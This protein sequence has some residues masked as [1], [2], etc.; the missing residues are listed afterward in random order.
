MPI[1]KDRILYEDAA[2]LAVNKLSGELVVKGS[3]AVGKL[4]LLDFL[5]KDYPGIRPL[6]RLDFDTSGVVLF[7]RTKA[8]FEKAM[9]VGKKQSHE[10]EL[11]DAGWTKTYRALVAGRLQRDKGEITKPLPAR[12]G[13]G[14]VSAHTA[15]KVLERFANSSYVEIV[16]TTGRHHQIRK[17]FASIEH[18]LVNDMVYGNRKYNRVF[19]QELHYKKFFLHAW[20]MTL[21]HPTT[22]EALSIEAPLPKPFEDV[23]QKLRDLL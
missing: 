6:N 8:A 14:E 11:S 4:P 23:L 5:R 10:T 7:A 15:Y 2:L 13:R 12:S 1:N 21:S 18:P 9:S 16:I 17:H 3:G 20:K 22:G 19:I